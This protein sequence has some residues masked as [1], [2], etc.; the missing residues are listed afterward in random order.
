M[1]Y[2]LSRT[3]PPGKAAAYD[4]PISVVKTFLIL[5][6]TSTEYS[7]DNVTGIDTC[8]KLYAPAYATVAPEVGLRGQLEKSCIWQ[9]LRALEVAASC[10]LFFLF[11]SF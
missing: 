8:E 7:F 3:L 11:F 1:K 5:A 2:H 9:C 10:C 4:T 6:N